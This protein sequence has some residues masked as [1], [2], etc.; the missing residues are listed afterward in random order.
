MQQDDPQRD[1]SSAQTHGQQDARFG[2]KS[3]ELTGGPIPASLIA[4][5]VSLEAA[6][7]AVKLIECIGKRGRDVDGRSWS[8]PST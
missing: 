8:N 7:E 3:I 2:Y 1:R 5:N 6:L 4:S